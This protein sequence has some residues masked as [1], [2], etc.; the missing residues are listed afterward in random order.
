MVMGGTMRSV[1]RALADLNEGMGS[2]L[3]IG[4]ARPALVD[5]L[6]AGNRRGRTPPR[7]ARSAPLR[8][9]RSD[10]PAKPHLVRIK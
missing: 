10:A 4:E 8:V 7:R 9:A 3:G 6:L 1:R 2:L 5:E